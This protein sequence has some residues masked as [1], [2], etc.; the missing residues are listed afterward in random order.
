M[1]GTK[2]GGL[3]AAQTNRQKYGDN[4]YQKIGRLGGEHS[5]TGG[6]AKNPDLARLAGAKGGKRSRRGQ[7]IMMQKIESHR[8]GIRDLYNYGMSIPQISKQFKISDAT[9]RKWA[10]E[11]LEG[12]GGYWEGK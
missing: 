6:F 11:N 8:E 10:K 4:F 9:L 5:H 2:I 3:K 1:P 7:S 12:Y